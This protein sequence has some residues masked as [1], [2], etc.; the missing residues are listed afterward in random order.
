M[1]DKHSRPAAASFS[2]MPAGEVC[3]AGEAAA[4]KLMF[5]G[6]FSTWTRISRADDEY[7]L[8]QNTFPLYLSI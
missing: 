1:A 5:H 6:E 3:A 4:E 7:S 2:H 8:R